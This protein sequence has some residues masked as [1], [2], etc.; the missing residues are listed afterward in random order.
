MPTTTTNL[1]A[2]TVALMQTA[3]LLATIC[4]PPSLV[5]VVT[6]TGRADFVLTGSKRLKVTSH[7]D[8]GVLY[9][10]SSVVVKRG[11]YI[12]HA[13][14]NEKALLVLDADGNRRSKKHKK[15]VGRISFLKA[16]D[17]S[18]VKISGGC[19]SDLDAKGTSTVNISGGKVW[20]LHIQDSSSAEISGG[21]VDSLHAEANSTVKISG[22][23]I[24][25]SRML[26]VWGNSS[27]EITGG[28]FRNLRLVG[29]TATMKIS[30][31]SFH[32]SSSLSVLENSTVTFYGSDF[33]TTG[34]NL[35]L[36][37][38]RLF[39][40]GLLTGKWFDRTPWAIEIKQNPA[41]A[42]ISTISEKPLP[43]KPL[44]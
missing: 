38:G 35:R 27:V 29:P 25:R 15:P 42:T 31:G 20:S 7:H 14:V 23:N 9:E 28:K 12:Q 36:E 21:Y 4:L 37:K 2:R 18:T 17:T 3:W 11:G 41:T 22:G 26:D 34:G 13:Y 39:G 8:K 33:R 24:C 10:S 43:E 44:P 1:L 16:F 30:G 5:L 19:T 32:E 6:D 40:T